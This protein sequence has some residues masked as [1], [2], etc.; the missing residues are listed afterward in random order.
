[1]KISVRVFCWNIAE[2]SN[3]G[4]VAPNGYL[5]RIAQ[6][7]QSQTPDIV[8]LNEVRHWDLW[9]GGGIGQYMRQT[10]VLASLVRLP[11]FNSAPSVRMG[12]TGHKVNSIITRYPLGSPINH[13]IRNGNRITGYSILQS[14]L[15]LGNIEFQTFSTRFDAWNE[16]DNVAAHRQA[17]DLVKG[18]DQNIPIIFGGDFNASVAADPQFNIFISES[19]MTKVPIEYLDQSPCTNEP[20]TAIDHIF[21]RGNFGIREPAMRCPWSSTEPLSEHPWLSVELICPPEGF[22]AHFGSNVK[23]KHVLTGALLHS[24][25]Y[26]Y[27]HNGTSGQQQVTGFMGYDGNDYWQIKGKHGE[28]KDARNGEIVKHGDILRLTHVST[29]RNLHSHAGFPSPMSNQQEVAAYGEDGEG[30]ENDNWRVEAESGG[31]VEADRNFRLIHCATGFALHSHSGFGHQEWTMG[32]Q[33]VT[34]YADRD[35]NDL[36]RLVEVQ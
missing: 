17:T 29:G 12:W 7:I 15:N 10:E 13:S 18:L 19:G 35:D 32:Q 36:W 6:Q 16:A 23:I 14:S 5:D 21:Y 22:V 27:G 4:T 20:L 28:P 34:A 24:H 25:S 2:A 9:V 31:S 11:N 1:M 33:E 8:L 26:S 30:D 3:T